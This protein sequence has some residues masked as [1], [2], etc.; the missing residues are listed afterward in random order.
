LCLVASG[1]ARL[2]AVSARRGARGRILLDLTAG[3]L[4]RVRGDWDEA[5]ALYRSV[6]LDPVTLAGLGLG[7]V[8]I[9]PVLVKNFLG[10]AALLSADL[11]AAERDLGAAVS[12]ELE[13]RPLPQLNAAA[14]LSLVRCERGELG[15]AQSEALEV[16]KTAAEAG[17][18]RAPQVVG[19]YLAM[20]RVALD[21]L[22]PEEFDD[23]LG[24]AAAVESAAAEPHVRAEIALLLAARRHSAG[25]RERALSGLRATASEIDVATL[26]RRMGERWSLAEAGLLVGLGDR[27][28]A[29]AILDRLP[30]ASST[31][32]VFGTARLRMQLG[33]VPAAVAARAGV[34]PERHPRGTVDASL[35]D[36]A[37]ALASEDVE[38]ALDRLEE[39]L[40]A[41][42]P[43]FLRRPFLAEAVDLRPILERRLAAGTVVPGFAVDVLGRLSGA[44]AAVPDSSAVDPLTERERTVLRYLA[45]TMSNAEIA[46][47]LYVSVNTVKTHERALYR[48]LDV[49]NRREAVGRARELGL[50]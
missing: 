34:Q 9:V 28:Q 39:A 19:A 5:L 38:T 40:A 41:A 30:P 11:E 31:A 45:S 25:D 13:P 14:Y 32:T 47:V 49:T 20:A 6:P 7:R 1:R 2:G 27:Q 44:P 8:E 3:A 10:M 43:W 29:R 42:A 26:P 50:L 17:L 18:D 48:K 16:V 46:A 24:R 12:V 15:P 23:W 4:A 35:L 33:D 37:L 21:R 22:H 36:T